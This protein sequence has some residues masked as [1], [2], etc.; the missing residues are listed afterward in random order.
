[1]ISLKDFVL[2]ENDIERN[3][4]IYCKECG[5][6]VDGEL[7]DIGFTKFIPRIKCE[8]E[9]KRDKE[10]EER[11]ILTRIS[12]LKRDLKIMTRVN[13]C[14]PRIRRWKGFLRVLIIK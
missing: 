2:R 5:K 1:M 4:H 13:T 14:R 8:C 10:N 6:R 3:G 12:S 9:I 7:L 11:E